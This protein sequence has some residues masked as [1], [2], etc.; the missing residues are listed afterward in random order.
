MIL[1]K[2]I[3]NV[4]ATIKEKDYEAKKVLVI[5]PIDAVTGKTKGKSFLAIDTVQAGVGD[6]VIVI[7]EG[8]SARIILG[9]SKILTIR[10]IVAGIV[11]HVNLS[12]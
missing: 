9:N 1:G 4:V 2:V 12:L 11:D 5:N 7:D 3:G 10:T 6:T 8:G